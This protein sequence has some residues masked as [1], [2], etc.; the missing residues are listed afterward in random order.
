MRLSRPDCSSVI[1][2][3]PG[4]L[5][6]G[7]GKRRGREVLCHRSTVHQ[8]PCAAEIP[9]NICPDGESEYLHLQKEVILSENS[10]DH[11][12]GYRHTQPKQDEHHLS[13]LVAERSLFNH[14]EFFLKN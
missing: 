6:A 2:G 3:A 7:W 4:V 1:Q 13:L 10:R 5:P 8:G 12:L 9:A 11:P 14:T